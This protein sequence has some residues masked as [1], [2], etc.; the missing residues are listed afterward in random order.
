[1]NSSSVERIIK[2]LR[3]IVAQNYCHAITAI[4]APAQST[5][6]SNHQADHKTRWHYGPSHLV[7]STTFSISE[8]TA[9]SGSIFS[10]VL[11]R[12]EGNGTG[13]R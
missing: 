12:S 8:Y 4:P 10:P 7:P 13:V 3:I 1:M 5:H 9:L 11:V 6:R 2:L